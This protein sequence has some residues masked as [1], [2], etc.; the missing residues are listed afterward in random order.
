[1]KM[2]IFQKTT[3]LLHFCHIQEVGHHVKAVSKAS[4]IVTILDGL[5]RQK[6]KPKKADESISDKI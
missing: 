3:R 1:M 5:K 4:A 6:L 2:K